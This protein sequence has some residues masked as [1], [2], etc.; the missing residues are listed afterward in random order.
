MSERKRNR[1]LY[2]AVTR[3]GVFSET[4][5]KRFKV[6]LATLKRKDI[7]FC[8]RGVSLDLEF[9]TQPIVQLVEN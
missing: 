2:Y 8:C 3:D 7:I 6:M 9:K 5:E 4:S 1:Y